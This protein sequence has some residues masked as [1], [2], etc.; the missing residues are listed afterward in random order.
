[1]RADGQDTFGCA[2]DRR[3][4]VDIARKHHAFRRAARHMSRIAQ[5]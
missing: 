2:Y 1:L 4:L 5:E 3:N